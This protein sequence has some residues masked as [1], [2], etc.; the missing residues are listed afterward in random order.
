MELKLFES[1][2]L[3]E[4]GACSLSATEAVCYMCDGSNIIS[5]ATKRDPLFYHCKGLSVS[6]IAGTDDTRGTAFLYSSRNSSIYLA[7]LAENTQL[8]PLI[9]FS[10]DEPVVS[11]QALCCTK[12]AASSL[13][14]PDDVVKGKLVYFVVAATRTLLYS[15]AVSYSGTAKHVYISPSFA[16]NAIAAASVVN[17]PLPSASPDG[18]KPAY[19]K[20][21]AVA[22][23]DGKVQL[24]LPTLQQH[25]ANIGSKVHLSLQPEEHIVCL[26]SCYNHYFNI[27]YKELKQFVSERDNHRLPL[28]EHAYTLASTSAGSLLL[29]SFSADAL[30]SQVILESPTPLLPVICGELLEHSDHPTVIF[31]YASAK[32]ENAS[33]LRL[34]HLSPDTCSMT[35]AIDLDAKAVTDISIIPQAVVNAW[36]YTSQLFFVSRETLFL[37]C[38]TLKSLSSD[39]LNRLQAELDGIQNDYLPELREDVAALEEKL[40]ARSAKTSRDTP[41]SARNAD[42][43]FNEFSMSTNSVSA[44]FSVVCPKCLLTATVRVSCPVASVDFT[45]PRGLSV[46]SC[47]APFTASLLGV[48]R[49]VAENEIRLGLTPTAS[50]VPSSELRMGILA[51]PSNPKD[52][53]GEFVSP[54]LLTRLEIPPFAFMR[55]AP[56]LPQ[57]PASISI[58]ID[59]SAVQ[60]PLLSP[61]LT[62]PADFLAVHEKEDTFVIE[63]S[64]PYTAANALSYCVESELQEDS[65]YTSLPCVKEVKYNYNGILNRLN[66]FCKVFASADCDYEEAKLLQDIRMLCWA[67]DKS[68][69]SHTAGCIMALKVLKSGLDDCMRMAAQQIDGIVKSIM[70]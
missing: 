33:S 69:V 56:Q 11:L 1:T 9:L 7:I 39:T 32:N 70:S 2:S 57:I 30:S 20:A 27:D 24:F 45:I 65:N 21:L 60:R 61:K 49:V 29:L 43:P 23:M 3:L 14:V 5:M 44:S 31:A 63:A 47:S 66:A 46:A 38:A 25:S 48:L 36:P 41:L 40:A 35:V 10:V 34:C 22:H 59:K 26:S 18:L 64:S 28:R 16:G 62:S 55:P 12:E 67:Y 52:V 54:V 17:T 15:C 51:F 42:N 13:D 8:E 50:Y 6:A 19:L 37:G 68:H 53:P 4:R 58:T